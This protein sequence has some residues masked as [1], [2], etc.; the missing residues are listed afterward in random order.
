MPK[1][2]IVS[3]A[4]RN[5]FAMLAEWVHSIRQFHGPEDYDIGIVDA[6]LTS[7]QSTYLKSQGCLVK[8]IDWPCPVPA[9]K[10][11]GKEYLKGCL[12]RPH[13]P[14]IF[15]DHDMFVWMDSDT[16]AQRGDIIPGFIEAAGKDKIALTAQ[17]DRHYPRQIRIKWLGAIP[18]KLRG[19]YFS[20][21]KRCFGFAKAKELYPYHVLLAGMF[22]L[23]RDA[24][25]WK[26]CAELM[27]EAVQKGKVF[28]AEQ[29][30]LGILCYLEGYKKNILP[31]WMHW[32]C[33]FKPLWNEETGKFVEPYYPH[34]TLGIL[35]L[36]G[37]DEMRVNRALTT[38]FETLQGGTAQKSYRYADFDGEAAL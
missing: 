3:A 28:T 27:A 17:V 11:K 9:H 19:F 21:A 12:C 37:W 20:N 15:P 35:H 29:L 18:L 38:D 33:E 23:H 25:H 26:R 30:T 10:V 8:Q 6:G 36:S 2:L 14:E 1:T 4:D 31:G 16:W 34:E 24:P 32:L 22:A 5:Y 7:D 13:L